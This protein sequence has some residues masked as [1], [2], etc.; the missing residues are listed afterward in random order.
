MNRPSFKFRFRATA[1]L[2]LLGLGTGAYAWFGNIFGPGT[3]AKTGIVF[4]ALEVIEAEHGVG[5][6]S[7]NVDAEVYTSNY[8][9]FFPSRTVYLGCHAPG[10]IVNLGITQ[11]SQLRFGF[12]GEDICNMGEIF[13]VATVTNGEDFRNNKTLRLGHSNGEPG[14]VRVGDGFAPCSSMICTNG[15]TVVPP[16]CPEPQCPPACPPTVTCPAGYRSYYPFQ[17]A[18]ISKPQPV[19]EVGAEGIKTF[20][21]N[22]ADAAELQQLIAAVGANNLRL[23]INYTGG[24]DLPRAIFATTGGSSF[25]ISPTTTGTPIPL[26]G[27]GGTVAVTAASSCY[28]VAQRFLNSSFINIT[29]GS[30][31]TGNGTVNYSVD[32]Y[33]G[34]VP[35]TGTLLIA[36]QTF[37]A[38]QAGLCPLSGSMVIGQTL[39][40]LLSSTDCQSAIVCG[41][42]SRSSRS[43]FYTF[44]GTAGQQIAISLNSTD[45]D[46]YLNLYD[47]EGVQIACDDDGG[48]DVNSRIPAESGV[49]ALPRTGT[50]TIRVGSFAAGGAGNYTLMLSGSCLGITTNPT[51]KAA[52]AGSN[53]SFTAAA[54]GGAT[55]TV[56]WQELRPG[57]TTF[58]DIAGATGTTLTLTAVTTTQNGYRYRAVFSNAC[59][60]ATTAAATLNVAS[61]PPAIT[62]QPASQ[63]KCVGQT[64][65]FSVSA[66]G[67][68]LTYQWR[69]NGSNIPGATSSSYTIPAVTIGDAGSYSVIVTGP[70]GSVTSNPATLTVNTPPAITSQ[71]VSLTRCAGQSATFCV[72]ASGTGLSYQWRKNGVNIPG[73]T[74]N[75]YTIA[76]VGAGD[77]GSY[78]VVVTNA[79]GGLT[80]N[81]STLTVNSPPNIMTNPMDQT[82]CAGGSVSFTAA[83]SGNPAPTVQWQVSTNGGGSFT[84]VPG[85]TSTTL[86]FTASA[87]QNGNLYRA[88]FTNTCGTNNTAAAILTVT[89]TCG[90]LQYYPLPFPIRLL[91]TRP[92]ENA[93]FAPGAPLGNDAVRTQPATGTCLGATIPSTAK[94]IVGNATVVNF[95]SSGSHWITL[96]PSDAGQP[97][98]SNLNFSG[99]QI[100]PNNFTVGLG[101]DGAFKIYSHAST[102]FIVDITG[103][104]APPGTGG[105]YYHP[106]PAPVRLFDSR[107]GE[108]ACDAPGA[109]L[110][111][112]GT[113]T[114][115][116]HRTCFGATIPSTAK[117]VVGNATV[118]NFISSGSH[119]I[120]LYPFGTPQP[121]AS[122]L[123]FIANQIVPNAFVVG[124]SSD[125]KFNIYSHAATH[126]IVDVTGYFSSEQAD[127]NGQGL[128][129]NALPTPVR[130]LDTRPG[131]PG[132]D[133]PGATLGNDATRTQAAHRTCFGV[134][135]PS[136]AKALVGNA[137][138]VNFISSGFH[139]IT[140]YPFGAPQ[141]NASNLNFHEN[142]IVPNAFFVGLS[143]DG[144]FNIYSHASTHFIVDLT[145]Y[146]A[147]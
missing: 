27:G 69:K 97:N 33:S 147:P 141:P 6:E 65:T 92:G 84:N 95:I 14:A 133:A 137:T 16:T 59:G 94:A 101:P 42:D 135:V 11:A 8:L 106:L 54:S 116:A 41:S 80:S 129:Y 123:N 111:N 108:S 113:R 115:L 125:G 120:T 109:P 49:F 68:G 110:V 37:T 71:P 12:M 124:L 82:V 89:Q 57:C 17:V 77:A 146:F 127:V 91:D 140:L 20:M 128:L 104:Y 18:F 136:A 145:G 24:S 23:G 22:S 5:F 50:Y 144:K 99:N 142:Q 73:A 9:R 25:T 34:V 143:N 28:W 131:E 30:S 74:S 29:S 10:P 63:T 85:G 64:A 67:A 15:T 122:N 19:G 44:G 56:K 21:L 117:A 139:W 45:F 3:E 100:V 35:R 40:S 72:T 55:P 2:C 76:S 48:I 36:G 107:P 119:W 31:G 112:D 75:C 78:S 130:L 43:D 79:C 132:C 81:P 52:C 61:A 103:Y 90:G 46:T 98:A 105:L 66:T 53:V 118:V 96:Y 51:D 60:A 4:D 126:F 62:S 39:N 138:V 87:A 114:L 38:N 32:P 102:H 47:S 83:A 26:G 58:T 13:V 121:N 93:C 7:F 88:V 86:T 134:T 1:L 70:C